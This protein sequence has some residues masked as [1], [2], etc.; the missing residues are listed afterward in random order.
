LGGTVYFEVFDQEKGE[1]LP[2]DPWGSGIKNITTLFVP[3][4]DQTLSASSPKLDTTARYLYVYQTVNDRGPDSGNVKMSTVR[5]LLDPQHITSWGHFGG[6]SGDKEGAA[7]GVS[8]TFESGEGKVVGVSTATPNVSDRAYRDPAPARP[9]PRPFGLGDIPLADGAVAVADAGVDPGR[10]PERV[11]LM[12]SA[13]FEGTPL[14]QRHLRVVPWGTSNSE[15]DGRRYGLGAFN[16]GLYNA[17]PLLYSSLVSPDY[18]PAAL[19]SSP[20]LPGYSALP[21]GTSTSWTSWTSYGSVAPTSGTVPYP[22][23][24]RDWDRSPA[25][26]A[27]WLNA[28]LAPTQRSTLWG[29]TSNYPPV[30]DDLRLRGN[31]ALVN[32]LVDELGPDVRPANLRADGE[33]PTPVAPVAFE[34]G[35]AGGASGGWGTTA[36]SWGGTNPSSGGGTGGGGFSGGGGGFGGGRGGGAAGGGAAGGGGGLSGGGGTSGNPNFPNNNNGT[37]A[38]AQ[39][40]PQAQLQIVNVRVNVQTTVTNQGCC[41]CNNM[42][43]PQTVPEP[44]AFVAAMLGLFPLAYVFF[45]R[46]PSPADSGVA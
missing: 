4:T 28:P 27:L 5:L 46:R 43:P 36:G 6:R 37:Q 7:R 14:R 25:V 11:V 15:W 21:W 45:R 32:R 33:V 24:A 13:D 20:Y 16:A 31:P 23:T 1:G 44:A 22:R 17:P 40:Q 10:A 26:R 42:P 39:F 8:F 2:G 12:R 9:V 35:G 19:V 18:R 41:C 29:F 38:Q 3:G 34:S 30:Y